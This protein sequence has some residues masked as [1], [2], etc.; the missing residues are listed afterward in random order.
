MTFAQRKTTQSG[1][2]SNQLYQMPWSDTD[3]AMASLEV[4]RDCN[5][6]CDYCCQRHEKHSAKTLDALQIELNVLVALRNCDTLVVT[7]GEPLLHPQ[8]VEVVKMVKAKGKK[9]VLLT[10]GELL[11]HDGLRVLVEAGLFGVTFHVDSKQ[12]RP[13]WEACSEETL[14]EL[15]EWFARLVAPF[16]IHC[17]FS[18]VVFSDTLEEV[19]QLAQWSERHANLVHTMMFIA[20]RTSSADDP[21]EYY[22]HGRRISISQTAYAAKT[23]EQSVSSMDLYDQIQKVFPGYRFNSFLGG[24]ASEGVLKWAMGNHLCRRGGRIG[25]LGPAAVGLVQRMG[26]KIT[27]RYFSLLSPKISRN[28]WVAFFLGILDP[29]TRH[30]FLRHLSSAI[31]R[32]VQLFHKL[33]LQTFIVVQPMDFLPSGGQDHCKGCPHMTVYHG[34]LVRGCEVESYL[35]HGGPFVTVPKRLPQLASREFY[36][37]TL[38]PPDPN[39]AVEMSAKEWKENE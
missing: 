14:N 22:V 30:T 13:G 23:F 11:T 19:Q 1:F 18:A 29:P 16:G 12:N 26:K 31:R 2:C 17:A 9:P 35:Q 20:A 37:T 28:G 3:N 10:N 24:T 4:T 6:G 39:C 8:L 21:W 7:G 5:L 33:Y 38:L 25:N 27:G 15:R 36:R 34:K 32:P